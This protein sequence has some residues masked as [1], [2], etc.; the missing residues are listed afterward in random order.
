MC[1][2]RLSLASLG[3][4]LQRNSGSSQ[5]SPGTG[6]DSCRSH[7]VGRSCGARIGKDASLKKRIL[8]FS[9]PVVSGD[10][11]DHRDKTGAPQSTTQYG[12]GI[13][14]M[15]VGATTSALL[16]L[17][18]SGAGGAGQRGYEKLRPP[19]GLVCCFTKLGRAGTNGRGR[20]RAEIDDARFS[21]GKETKS[22]CIDPDPSDL[23]CLALTARRGSSDKTACIA[24][25]PTTMPHLASSW[26]AERV[27]QG[28]VC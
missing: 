20:A 8:G 1:S 9:G 2:A 15:K 28:P 22:A 17:S 26:F 7:L 14:R 5:G 3:S 25:P 23:A 10:P 21:R 4:G 24:Y 6:I 11:A 16:S 19:R 13:F 18:P 12:A 27:V